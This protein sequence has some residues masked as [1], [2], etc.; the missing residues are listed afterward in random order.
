MFEKN[1]I[2]NLDCFSNIDT[3][4]EKNSIDLIM[5]DPPYN[6][7]ENSWEY[8]IDLEKL[9]NLF[10]YVL[11]D[12]G[13]VITT[14]SQP[15]TTK[16]INSN[17]KDFRYCLV[18]DKIGTTGFATANIMPLKRHEDI[19]IFYKKFS[20]Y[21]PQKEVRG[22]KRKKGGSQKDNGCYG[23]LR[24]LESFNNE[25]YPTSILE[26][27]NASKKGLIHPTQK[28]VELFSYLIKTYSNEGD[29]VLDTFS[30]SGTTAISCL[31]T[32]RNY[33]CFEKDE[34]HYKNS[35]ERIKQW[36][37]DQKTIF[38]IV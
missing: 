3:L 35:L 34:E 19:L 33:I 15:F 21:N 20:T 13:I 30:G 10:S 1:I 7:T 16:M 25:Y 23:S 5:T 26:F 14:A 11:K 12:T 22:K 29:L 38:D 17:I 36:H 8:E 9:W 31:E 4:I 6:T 28:P 18:W 32:K 24:S 2:H 37:E 27:S